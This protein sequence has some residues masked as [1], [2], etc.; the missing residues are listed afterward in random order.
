MKDAER[1]L[2]VGQMDHIA[3]AEILK[4]WSQAHRPS[5]SSICV[6]MAKFDYRLSESA[7]YSLLNARLGGD[8]IKQTKRPFIT[9]STI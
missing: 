2:R 7:A 9:V 1:A 4:Y 5:T 6:I 8:T 3:V